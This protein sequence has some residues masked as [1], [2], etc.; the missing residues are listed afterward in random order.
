[1][2][3]VK[4]GDVL[5]KTSTIKWKEQESDQTYSYIDLTSVDRS[6]HV[7]TQTSDIT[8]KN[9]PSRAQKIVKT[10]DVIFGTTRPTLNRLCIVPEEYDEQICSTGF[11][12]LRANPK[13]ITS[14]F[15]YYLLITK[16]FVEY[17]EAT[18]RG[19]SYPAVTDKDVKQFEFVLPSPEE[20]RRIVARLDTAFEW[21][22]RAI[23]LIQEN[24]INSGLLFGGLL[25]SAVAQNSDI[26]NSTIGEIADVEYG[27][28][29]KA[30]SAGELRLV[31]IT[32]I[33]SDGFLNTE[34]AVYVNT[35]PGL[36]RYLLTDGDLVVART[37]AT[38]GKV[39]YFDSSTPSV[40]ASY[41][42]RIN[43]KKDIHPKL[44]WYYTK[45]PRYWE[46]A[47]ILSS[48]TAQPQF[49]GNALKSIKF[50]YPR[51]ADDQRE[52]V[53]KLDAYQQSTSKLKNAYTKKLTKLTD[54]RQ[55]LLA[56]AFMTTNRVK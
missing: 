10:G 33:N 51:N 19:T 8:S 36:E 42:I 30:S 18:Q 20:Q 52:I 37:G 12:V 6:K 34:N 28:T 38:F 29:K 3:T 55:S 44:F 22:D 15:I 26:V 46:Q 47:N 1:M 35:A 54:L 21:I 16:A 27:L 56:E 2:K 11:C 9:A 39:L 23:E 4:L 13:V 53:N 7:I 48:G 14:S 5:L 43:F 40:F 32:D 45:T 17:V 25:D 41:L 31:R 24:V 50:S 49:N